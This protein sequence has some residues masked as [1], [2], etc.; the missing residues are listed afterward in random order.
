MANHHTV[1]FTATTHTAPDTLSLTPIL[2]TIENEQQIARSELLAEM[3]AIQ[4]VSIS[5]TTYDSKFTCY[6]PG[7][8]QSKKGNGVP[9]NESWCAEKYG[10]IDQV[11][12][13]Y[14][15]D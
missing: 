13:L 10:G 14:Y 7:T 6:D 2:I 15:F 11:N 8:G 3:L 1:V 9:Y 4:T 12:Y 5:S